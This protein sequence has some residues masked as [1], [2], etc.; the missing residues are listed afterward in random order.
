M[1]IFRNVSIF[2][3]LLASCASPS[4]ATNQPPTVS[5]GTDQTVALPADEVVLNGTA[6]DPDEG[7]TLS[8]TWSQTAGLPGVSFSDANSLLTAAAFPGLGSYTLSLAVSDGEAS[9][10]DEV[11]VT[12]VAEEPQG[13]GT[14]ESLPQ[15][16][17]ARQEVSY[18]QVGGKFYLAGGS[19]LHEVYDPVARTWATLTPLP[20][21]LD[22]IQGVTLGGKIYYIGGCQNGNLSSETNSV[23]VYDPVTDSFSEGLEMTRPRCAGG[24][25]VH[26]GKIYYYSGLNGG[27]AQTWFDV[28]DPV[29]NTW[30]QLPDMPRPR[31]H[32][33]AAV[34]NGVLYAISGRDADIDATNNAVDAFDF[35]SGAWTTLTTTIPTER[36][37]FSAAVVGNE[38]LIIGGEG[39]GNTYA[40][41]EALNPKTETWRTLTP[42]PTPRHGI[43]AAVCNGGVYIAAGGIRQGVGPSTTHEVLFPGEPAPCT[44][45]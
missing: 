6:S 7:T 32:S 19:T 5:A 42:M 44:G 31:D 43:Q 41:V 12:V 27:E 1:T 30:T 4:G 20:A 3:L 35:A 18:V 11:A 28:Y 34:L 13:E 36:G 2:V 17:G 26:E 10:T 14:W 37:G 29:A 9:A 38:I 45:D 33:Q 39:D 25:A 21:D 24:V 40:E 16:S 23:Y 15:T 8:A 22:H